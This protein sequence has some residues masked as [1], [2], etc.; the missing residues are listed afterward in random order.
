MSS[1]THPIEFYMYV[2]LYDLGAARVGLNRQFR[3]ILR[4]KEYKVAYNEYEGGHGH[5]N[6]RHTISDGLIHFFAD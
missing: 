3:D 4:L 5:L 2:G 6:W 1:K